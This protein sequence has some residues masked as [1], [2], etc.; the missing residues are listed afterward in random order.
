MSN[1]TPLRATR[2][3]WIDMAVIALPCPIYAMDI[4]EG[5]TTGRRGRLG[6]RAAGLRG[7]GAH[8]ARKSPR[9]DAFDRSRCRFRD[10]PGVVLMPDCR[11]GL[12][13]ANVLR[14]LAAPAPAPSNHIKEPQ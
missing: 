2:R 10:R 9:P 1:T 12:L 3:E 7:D 4:R 5:D 14:S 11:A 6:D 13:I 8:P